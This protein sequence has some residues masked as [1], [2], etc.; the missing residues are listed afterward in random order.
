MTPIETTPEVQVR[1]SPKAEAIESCGTVT[2]SF[3]GLAVRNVLFATDFSPVSEAALP[4]AT[5]ICRRFASTLHLVH[6]LSDTGLLMMSGGIDYVSLGTIYEDA[7]TEAKEKLDDI[8]LQCGE[9]PHRCHVR[10]G[11]VWKNL[12]EVIEANRIDLMIVGTHGRG[13][14]G[15]LLLGS[16]AEDILRHAPCPVLT[17]GPMVS[18]HAKLP[19]ID[20]RHRDVA[21]AELELCEILFATNFS[22]NAARAARAA[23]RLAEEFHARL[24][25]LHV[26]ENYS[27]LGSRPGPME[28]GLRRLQELVP[29]NAALQYAPERALEFGS[30]SESILRI[31]A[32]RQADMIVLGARTTT[33][34]GGTHLPWS[35]AHHVLAN[36][37]CPVLT[38]RG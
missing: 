22:A 36:A 19:A 9:M 4:Y 13:G 21:P 24:T 26:I 20:K 2:T 37:H 35:T 14:F 25:L 10:H 15:K 17:V 12:A 32:E 27:D 11:L 31:A 3:A 23:V 8:A 18:G 1:V 33:E 5:A 16:I 34:V 28:A 30:A 7:H 29:E 6:V 38:V